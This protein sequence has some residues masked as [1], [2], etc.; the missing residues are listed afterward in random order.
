LAGGGAACSGR[1]PVI[2]GSG[3]TCERAGRYGRGSG[4]L[5]R[6]GAVH[7]RLWNGE[8]TRACIGERG[9]RTGV[10]QGCQPRS[11]MWNRCFCP[12]SNANWAQ[13]FVNLGKIAVKD[14]FP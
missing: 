10:N 7:G 13:I 8:R 3:R 5:Y 4:L 1:I 6:H 2:F 11:N 14:L 9:A 12:S